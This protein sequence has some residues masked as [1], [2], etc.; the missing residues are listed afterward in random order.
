MEAELESSATAG[1]VGGPARV[2]SKEYGVRSK[3]L[4]DLTCR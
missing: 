4:K 2:G 1:R 3:A